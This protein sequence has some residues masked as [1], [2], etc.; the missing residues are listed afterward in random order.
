MTISRRDF[1]KITALTGTAVGIGVSSLRHISNFGKLQKISENHHLM[2]TFINFV[3]L[4]ESKAAAHDAI[5]S[6]VDEMRRLIRMYDHRQQDSPLGELNLNGI[7]Q[8]VPPELVATLQQALYFS[9]LSY[10]A[11]DVTVKPVLDALR[12]GYPDW[13]RFKELVD[14]RQLCVNED[15]ISLAHTGMSITLDGIAKGSVVDGGVS[16]LR[17][18][19]YQNVLVEAGGDI[20]AKGMPY[21]ETWNIGIVHPR[22]PGEYIVRV[23]LDN[24]AIATSGD[25]MNYFS[26]D[27]SSYHIIDPRTGSSP[28]Q[29][30]SAS[31]I[32][33]SAAEADALSTTMMVLGV[34]DGLDMIEQLP[35]TVALLVTKDL[36]IHRS[37]RF[38]SEKF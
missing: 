36:K 11:F 26:P 33:P 38:P 28:S 1:L 32:A 8:H 5:Q 35:D 31:V 34:Q 19:G 22:I 14:Y 23:P 4:A 37:K 7:T 24:Q 6:T 29:L 3:I 15:T 9:R 16:T 2:G 25:Y 18:L 30:A 10:G 27:F 12:E 21:G 20:M 13:Q 17:R